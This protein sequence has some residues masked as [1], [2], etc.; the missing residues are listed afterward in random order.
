MRLFSS[1][2]ITLSF[3]AT[4]ILAH[5][6]DISK[7]KSPTEFKLP[8]EA[9]IEDIIDQMPDFNGLMNGLL[10]ISQ[11]ES[12]M[13]SLER[14]GEKLSERMETFEDVPEQ[15]NGMPDLNGLMATMLRTFSDEDFMDEMLDVATE[16]QRSVEENL[17]V[18]LDIV[19]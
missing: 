8:T 9:E 13:N 10:K 12:L 14:A 5:A 17:D 19:E 18:E 16:L 6:H 2:I 1:A 11:D 15:E 3:L 7:K 4:P